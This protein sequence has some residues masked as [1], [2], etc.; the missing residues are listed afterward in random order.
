MF[1]EKNNEQ[2]PT[3]RLISKTRISSGGF[4]CADQKRSIIADVRLQ[5]IKPTIDLILA[6]GGKII[7]ATHIGRPKN[8]EP[9]LSTRM[10]IPWFEKQ[11][12]RY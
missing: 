7:L 3:E 9:Y 12:Y 4:K 10:L 11:G 1:Y 2:T 6:K 8:H 5:A